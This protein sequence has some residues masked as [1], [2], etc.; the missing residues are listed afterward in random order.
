[1][2]SF[3]LTLFDAN[4]FI[5]DL[6]TDGSVFDGS[7]D[8]FD[9]GFDLQGF[10]S[11]FDSD[12]S[13]NGRQHLLTA[14]SFTDPGI[15]LTRKIFVPDSSAW[16]RY[17]DSATNTTGSA[18]TYTFRIDTDLGSDSG[19]QVLQTSNGNTTF[20][21]ADTFVITDDGNGTAGG[22][23]VVG[24]FFAAPG[25]L[26]TDAGINFSDDLFYEYQVTIQPGE[27]VSLLHFGIQG[28]TVGEVS[29]TRATINNQ[30]INGTGDAGIGLSQDD[31]SNIF[32]FNFPNTS[33]I[34]GNGPERWLGKSE[35]VV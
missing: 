31:L 30:L 28:N 13:L 21:E 18:I 7:M 4:G 2:T 16:I 20:N 32:N 14:N 1:M 15:A 29:Q 23:P 3:P 26:P 12:A 5:W 6:Q 33:F 19:T 25:N 9:G 22:D 34:G 10:G 35:Q 24:H 11:D 27:T 8:A 17:V